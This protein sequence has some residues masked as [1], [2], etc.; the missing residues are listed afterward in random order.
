MVTVAHLIIFYAIG[1]IRAVNLIFFFINF[2]LYSGKWMLLSCLKTV[3]AIISMIHCTSIYL[4]HYL[5]LFEQS[6]CY[7]FVN[8]G[9]VASFW[10]VDATF[11]A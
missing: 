11:L 9:N 1:S 6:I 2:W 3:A 4:L 7:S 8:F 10:Q 5:D